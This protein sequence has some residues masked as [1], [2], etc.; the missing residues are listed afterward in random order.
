MKINELQKKQLPLSWCNWNANQRKKNSVMQ[1]QKEQQTKTVN[2]LTLVW[3]ESDNRFMLPIQD[4]GQKKIL[5]DEQ[6]NV[7]I[8]VMIQNASFIYRDRTATKTD[9]TTIQERLLIGKN[10][11][12]QQVEI[13]DP[14]FLKQVILSKKL[15]FQKQLIESA[16]SASGFF[17]VGLI[18]TI[19]MFFWELVSSLSLVAESFALGS[20]EAMN[21]VGYFLSWIAGIL[22]IVLLAKFLVPLIWRTSMSSFVSTIEESQDAS[23]QQPVTNINVTHIQ[24]GGHSAQDFINNRHV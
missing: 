21:E 10:A 24:N 8:E 3:S 17:L 2:G 16:Q 19:V 14:E 22:V 18:I 12:G 9:G 20:K 4:E 13:A 15:E 23:T 11:A 5:W 7:F 1:Q 6:S